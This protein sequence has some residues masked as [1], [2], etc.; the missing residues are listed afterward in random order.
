MLKLAVAAPIIF[1]QLL[2][3]ITTLPTSQPLTLPDYYKKHIRVEC[4]E[5]YAIVHNV[6]V[7][8]SNKPKFYKTYLLKTCRVD[9]KYKY[10]TK[11]YPAISDSEKRLFLIS[12]AHRLPATFKPSK[13]TCISKSLCLD[14]TA[15]KA[16]RKMQKAAQ[17]EG[18]ALVLTS[19][20]R[21]FETQERLLY[22]YLRYDPYEKVV[23]YLALPGHSMHQTGLALDVGV[24]YKG[25]VY[26][27]YD[28]YKTP[29]T[30]WLSKNC[31][32]FGFIQPYM[33]KRPGQPL[34]YDKEPWH[35]LY[36]GEKLAKDYKT[37]PLAYENWVVQKLSNKGVGQNALIPHFAPPLKLSP[38]PMVVEML[39]IR[40]VVQK[41]WEKSNF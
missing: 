1:L 11:I 23:S 3:P 8:T 27:T 18:V 24:K 34:E 35:I 9:Q 6:W 31:Y 33:P 29:G 15:Y 28:I 13:L 25:K 4:K 26:H 21:S 5:S 14:T 32:K 19:G 2:L 30:K 40:R 20:Y 7:Y 10:P 37:S 39:P 41:T 36:V 12:K 22:Y 16:F 38:F 17:K